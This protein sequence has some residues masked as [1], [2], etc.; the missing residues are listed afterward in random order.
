MKASRILLEMSLFF[1]AFFLP[2]YLAQTHPPANGPASTLA[3]LQVIV[4]GLPQFMLMVYVAGLTPGKKPRHWGLVSLAPRDAMRILVLLVGCFAVVS[5]FV[6]L[7]LALPPQFSKSLTLG[8]RWGLLS[9][10]QVPV[11]LLFGLTAGYREEF[12]FRSYLLGRLGQLDI[13]LPV[14]AAASTALF[15]LGH[16]YE[17]PLGVAIAAGL[18]A[19]FAAVYLRRPNLHVIAI[20]HGLY[21]AIVLWLSL[22][23]P[24]SLP[25]AAGSFIFRP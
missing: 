3:M 8:Y 11:A 7:A 1:L 10:A 9:A 18:G 15:C 2:G 5:P 21:N 14:A 25:A 6:A 17:G 16:I 20:A 13:P 4:T 12:F 19:L 24:T 23:I 22:L